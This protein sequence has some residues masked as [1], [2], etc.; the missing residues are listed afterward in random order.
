M[1]K[2]VPTF[3]H[4]LYSSQSD[5]RQQSQPQPTPQRRRPGPRGIPPYI[6]G[7]NVWSPNT[8]GGVD[9]T[10]LMDLD[11]GAVHPA[12]LLRRFEHSRW[13]ASR[14]TAGPAAPPSWHAATRLA[15]RPKLTTQITQDY[16][17]V[18]TTQLEEA[19]S[20]FTHRP[21]QRKKPVPRLLDFCFDV[22]LKYVDD[23]SVIYVPEHG[24][25]IEQQ[26][27]ET[28][29][30]S[31]LLREQ[32][33]YLEPHLKTDLIDAASLLPE[34]SKHIS[35]RSYKAILYNLPPDVSDERDVAHESDWDTPDL[36]FHLTHLP[37][38]LH[39][40]PLTFFRSIPS[41]SSLT[42][43]NIAYS[44]I[45]DLEGLVDILP[46]GLREL[47]LAG[48]SIKKGEDSVKK[49]FIRLARKLI[50]LKVLD[51]SHPRFLLPISTLTTFFHPAETNLPSLRK[52]G[53]RGVQSQQM[54]GSFGISALPGSTD[55]GLHREKEAKRGIENIVRSGGRTRWVEII[56]G[57]DDEL[58]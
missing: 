14:T 49:G 51:L 19:S 54:I 17:P 38:T 18:T 46:K 48:I 35:D 22:F 55:D 39:P 58:S 27:N 43:I 31:R 26:E 15:S 44:T 3:K 52:L 30:M 24:E 25:E 1:P 41:I 11:N 12:E 33:A 36:D 20:L 42:S 2:H 10:L 40:C 57:D 34:A 37:L 56:W 5:I 9:A 4:L 28:Y 21:R 50:V 47:G 6:V 32:V 23:E 45:P 53:M 13:V 8:S 29:T 16:P 7:E